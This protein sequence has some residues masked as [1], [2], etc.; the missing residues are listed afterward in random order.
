M[1]VFTCV[2]LGVAAS[3]YLIGACSSRADTFGRGVG[4]VLAFA[5]II[6]LLHVAGLM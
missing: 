6:S 1:N 5:L 2:T 4:I 3:L